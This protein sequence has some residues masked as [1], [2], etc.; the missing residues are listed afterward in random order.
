M[1][2]AITALFVGWLV[3]YALLRWVRS[4]WEGS[5]EAARDRLLSTVGV[6]GG[7]PPFALRVLVAVLQMASWG[8]FSVLVAILVWR[9]A[10]RL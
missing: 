2:I 8:C 10:G 9:I 7:G 4:S 3:S 1:Q 5:D 6:D